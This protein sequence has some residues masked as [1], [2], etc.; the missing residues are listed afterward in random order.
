MH[1]L[2]IL[3]TSVHTVLDFCLFCLFVTVLCFVCFQVTSRPRW[4]QWRVITS[5]RGDG[6][7]WPRYPALAAPVPPFR[8]PT[9]CSSSEGCPRVPAMPW[10][11][12]A[13]KRPS[14]THIHTLM[15]NYTNPHML[16]FPECKLCKHTHAHTD[17]KLTCVS[18][19]NIH[20]LF[21]QRTHQLYTLN[22]GDN[23][24]ELGQRSTPLDRRVLDWRSKT[25]KKYLTISFI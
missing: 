19:T 23:L 9:C 12:S 10:K 5:W 17:V 7:P 14:D 6:N 8:P 15:N 3:R 16:Y 25:S 1:L 4:R 21:P 22:S 24:L 13:W 2:H 20:R 11:P 18:L